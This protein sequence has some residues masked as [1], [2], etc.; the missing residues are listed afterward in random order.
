MVLRKVSS[1]A[2]FVE[3][4]GVTFDPKIVAKNRKPFYELTVACKRCEVYFI[5]GRLEF[6]KFKGL[7]LGQYLFFATVLA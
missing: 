5:I 4:A 3:D 6:Q 2:W 1:A 7:L